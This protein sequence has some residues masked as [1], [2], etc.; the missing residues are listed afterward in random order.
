MPTPTRPEDLQS[1][2][3]AFRE[4]PLSA[5]NGRKTRVIE[6]ISK[7]SNDVLGVI[8]WYGAWRQYAFFPSDLSIWNSGCLA[9]V[10][11]AIHLLMEER[12][13]GRRT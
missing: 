6:I 9:D 12:R 2:Y 10:Q 8:R 11:E 13:V 3:L 4:H 7:R 5:A 1:E